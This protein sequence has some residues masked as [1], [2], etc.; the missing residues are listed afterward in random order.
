MEIV[1][2]LNEIKDGH[3]CL[4]LGPEPLPIQALALQRGKE[5]LAHGVVDTVR[6]IV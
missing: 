3:P 1:E 4:P 6:C 5:R 2:A